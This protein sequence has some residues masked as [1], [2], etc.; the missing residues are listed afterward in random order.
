[1]GNWNSGRRRQP[2]KLHALRGNPSKTRRALEPIAEAPGPE[3]DAPPVELAADPV[4]GAEWA[5]L[6]PLM[7]DAGI[8]AT[9]DRAALLALCQQWSLYLETLKQDDAR[10]GRALTFCLR[11][12]ADFG[13]TPGSRTKL[14]AVPT[15][16]R[17][18]PPTPPPG[19]WEGLIDVTPR[20]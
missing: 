17:R 12:W 8:V 16:G 20:K 15:G 7:R 10:A 11:L 6:A 18:Q 2:A 3:F 13:L 5:R 14:A 19:Q 4:A 9:V 1:M